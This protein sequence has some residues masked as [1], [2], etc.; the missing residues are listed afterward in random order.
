MGVYSYC[1]PSSRKTSLLLTDQTISL[2]YFPR[3]SLLY[4]Q[5]TRQFFIIIIR[6]NCILRLKY[7]KNGMAGS[8]FFKFMFF[9]KLGF[10]CWF[11]MPLKCVYLM[12][13][14]DGKPKFLSYLLLAELGNIYFFRFIASSVKGGQVS[15]F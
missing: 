13:C 1:L 3:L 15:S 12:V 11:E 14:L 7:I 6:N 9:F 2:L 10:K 5:W 4:G 8:E